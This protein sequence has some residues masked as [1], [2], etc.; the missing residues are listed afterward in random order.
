MQC[1]TDYIGKMKL[2]SRKPQPTSK[3]E[4]LSLPLHGEG[5][6]M[7]FVSGAQSGNVGYEEIWQIALHHA[8]D[9]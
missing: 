7:E 5:T 4:K 8:V 2:E 9:L 3:D 6:V 1:V